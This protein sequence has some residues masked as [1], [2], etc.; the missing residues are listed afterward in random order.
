MSWRRTFEEDAPV[1]QACSF[2]LSNMSFCMNYEGY[3][4]WLFPYVNYRP[5]QSGL[6]LILLQLE[7]MWC[8]AH[9]GSERVVVPPNPGLNGR[10]KK[11][12][13]VK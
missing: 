10:V 12:G 7:S 6:C 2:P 11:M 5:R 1:D 4:N 13:G 3:I 9:G 8:L